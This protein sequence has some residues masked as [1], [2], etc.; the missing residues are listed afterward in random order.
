MRQEAIALIALQGAVAAKE[1]QLAGYRAL[2]K[3]VSI[4]GYETFQRGKEENR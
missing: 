3:Q 1:K 4:S 2:Q